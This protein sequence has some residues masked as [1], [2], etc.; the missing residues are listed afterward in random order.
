MIGVKEESATFEV[1]SQGL[2]SFV[3]LSEVADPVKDTV[4][5]FL[6]WQLGRAAIV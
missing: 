4:I 6:Q 3:R 2:P 5:G 1:E